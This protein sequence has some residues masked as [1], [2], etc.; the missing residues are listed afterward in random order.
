MSHNPFEPPITRASKSN[1]VAQFSTRWHVVVI[2]N[3][4]LCFLGFAI[5]A[6][7]F[8]PSDAPDFFL[9][10]GAH[11]IA[12]GTLGGLSGLLNGP[13]SL[14]TLLRSLSFI[15]NSTLVARLLLLVLAGT[16][17][18]PLAVAAPVLIG[19]PALLNLITAAAG[20]VTSSK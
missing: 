8:I 12:C 19:A 11:L 18:G 20:R 6:L 1:S 9:Y 15:A 14:R 2:A 4:V 17:R 16:V 7:S 3:A 10:S 13:M 5:A